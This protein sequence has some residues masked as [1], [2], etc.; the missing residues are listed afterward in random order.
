[1]YRY[2]IKKAPD[3]FDPKLSL[4]GCLKDAGYK[5][6]SKLS[7]RAM[8]AKYGVNNKKLIHELIAN[9]FDMYNREINEELRQYQTSRSKG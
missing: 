6:L 7:L 5:T 9:E 4:I 3:Y 8:I 1:M 2:A